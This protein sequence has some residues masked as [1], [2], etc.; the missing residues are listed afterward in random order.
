MNMNIFF[1][2]FFSLK[3]NH[4]YTTA[5]KFDANVDVFCVTSFFSVLD[6]TCEQIVSTYTEK[7]KN[8]LEKIHSLNQEVEILL[9]IEKYFINYR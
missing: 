6:F 4:F 2:I 7:S 8:L 5:Y 1:L 9:V 3:I